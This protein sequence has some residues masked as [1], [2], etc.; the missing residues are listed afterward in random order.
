MQGVTDPAV[1]EAVRAYANLLRAGRSVVARVEPLLAAHQLTMTQF[2]VLEA[3]LHRGPLTHRELGRKV[4]TSAGNM[5]DVVDKL[6]ARHLVRRVR[7]P[8]DRRLVRVELTESGESLIRTLFPLHAA[9]IARVMSGLS[10]E[11]L[12]QLGELLRRLA[13]TAEHG[14][15]APLVITRHRA[16]F[17]TRS[18]DVER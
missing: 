1:K 18:F 15:A 5:T 2:G 17:C 16:H 4:L 14:Q 10:P 12:R 7:D 13:P 11:E 8:S 6:E 3:I 9:D